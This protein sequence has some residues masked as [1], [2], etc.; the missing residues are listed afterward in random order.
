M[1]FF[2]EAVEFLINEGLIYHSV[3]QEHLKAA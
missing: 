2:S 3:D 1:D